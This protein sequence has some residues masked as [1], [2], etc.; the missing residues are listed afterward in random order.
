MAEWFEE[1]FDSKYYHLLYKDRNYEE[2]ADFIDRLISYLDLP[3]DTKVLDVACGSGR[4]ALQFSRSGFQTTGIDLSANS[5]KEAKTYSSENLKFAVADMRD[6]ELQGRFELVTNLFTSF[7]YFS[8]LEDNLKVLQCISKHLSEEG[9]FV[10]DFMNTER[11]VS[12]LVAQSEKTVSDISF[13]LKRKYEDK[14]IFKEI[15]FVDEKGKNHRYE[16]RVQAIMYDDFEELFRKAGMTIVSSFGDYGLS[17]RYSSDS[18]R[19]IFVLKKE[20]R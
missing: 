10:L 20:S 6:F 2:A 3:K 7:G 19:M 17:K 9:I 11:I 8:D 15:K 4:H 5:I 1:W 14:K 18:D 12:N 16:E 13:Q